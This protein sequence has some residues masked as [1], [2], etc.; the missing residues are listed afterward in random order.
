VHLW[1]PGVQRVQ[2]EGGQ[3]PLLQGGAGGQEHWHGAPHSCHGVGGW[4][5]GGGDWG[6][7]EGEE[8]DSCRG[9]VFLHIFTGHPEAKPGKYT[10]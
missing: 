4:G 9:E 5:G 10:W 3:L 6:K 7:E 2:G 1:A 8:E